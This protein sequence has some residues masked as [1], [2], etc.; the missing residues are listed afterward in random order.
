MDLSSGQC[1]NLHTQFCKCSF[2]ERGGRPMEEEW[3]LLFK[4]NLIGRL[5]TARGMM[6]RES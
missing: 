2:S 6:L 1:A 3:S 5:A 4:D